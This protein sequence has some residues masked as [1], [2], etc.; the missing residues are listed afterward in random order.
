MPAI[1]T[2]RFAPTKACA[3]SSSR[4]PIR[5][6]VT[7]AAILDVG[8]LAIVHS[9]STR[10]GQ[11]LPP[12]GDLNALLD[13]GPDFADPRDLHRRRPHARDPQAAADGNGRVRIDSHRCV[14]LTRSARPDAVA[15]ARAHNCA[16]YP[17]S[18]PACVAMVLAQLSLRPIHVIRS[19]LTRLGQGEFGV[20]VDLPQRDEF[21]ELG[22]FFNT[23][24]ARLSADRPSPATALLAASL[25]N[26][27][28]G[29]GSA[30]RRGRDLQ[31]GREAAVR[32]PGDARH[33]ASRPTEPLARSV[34]DLFSAGTSVSQGGRRG[35]GESAVARPAFRRTCQASRRIASTRT[36]CRRRA[37]G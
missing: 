8:S 11:P 35:D 30:R 28:L 19:G 9:D 33:A 12:Y 37:S 26:A 14:N 20:V 36:G 17:R 6:N 34:R 10:I 7:Y 32:Q 18:A 31:P 24:S 3:R 29:Q 15:D 22:D 27:W 25:A 2:P 4:A 23:V 16:H 13:R 21:G 5:R 1:P